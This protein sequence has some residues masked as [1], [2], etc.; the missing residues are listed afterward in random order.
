MAKRSEPKTV[1]VPS[2]LPAPAPANTFAGTYVDHLVDLTVASL[3]SGTN[4]VAI[5][6]PGW[7]KTDVLSSVLM[8]VYGPAALK[9]EITP[10]LPPEAVTG[11]TDVSALLNES[12]LTHNTAGGPYDP[13]FK[14]LL[15]DEIG[16]ASE[17]ICDNLLF[18]LER[19]DVADPAPVIATS[20]FMPTSEHTRAMLD[21]FALWHW[22]KPTALDARA[23][24]RA[25]GMRLGRAGSPLTVAATL[26]TA[27]DIED[28][29]C[30]SY[31]DRAVDAVG[32]TVELLAAECQKT[33][34]Q[35]NPRRITQWTRLLLRAGLY[36]TG[37][38]DFAETPAAAVK[39]LRF[40]WPTLSEQEYIRWGKVIGNLSD[41]L[42]VAIEDVLSDAVSEFNR[43]AAIADVGARMGETAKLATY[44]ASKQSTLQALGN[45]KNDPRIPG[46]ITQLTTWF[47]AAAQGQ[48]VSRE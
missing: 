44:L 38:S 4:A 46:A 32:L 17:L 22:I 11:P 8:T 27:T 10:S 31:T 37:S 34:Y 14:A 13:Q 48:Q 29:R 6:A 24:A 23:V 30:A 7:G 20:N 45:G 43:V 42:A 5:G 39:L 47:S 2:T 1:L 21:R 36:Y 25:Q 28:I 33:G 12:R 15:F 26:P 16:R 41:P 9:L 19:K 3:L 35:L 40:A 18:L